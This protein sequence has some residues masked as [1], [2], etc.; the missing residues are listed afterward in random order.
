VRTAAQAKD[1]EPFLTDISKAGFEIKYF[2]GFNEPE[3][4]DQA[5][6]SVDEAVRLWRETVLPT[7]AK[8]GFRVGSPG[9][10]SDVSRSKPW[11]NSFFS[12]LGQD[13]GVDFLVVHWYGLRFEEM[14]R[15]LED[16]H[17][18]YG[19]PV[20]VNEFACSTMGNPGGQ[21]SITDVEKFIS[22]AVPWLDSCPWIERYAYYGHGQGKNVGDW[23][24]VANNLYETA[25]GC[26][27]TDGRQLSRVGRLYTEL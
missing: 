6:M 25:Q 22:E 8:L 15:F 2:L 9:M 18:T 21:S 27:Q 26:D 12:R 16:M 20:W 14:R 4:P 5:N 3:I 7:K 24:G 13:H 1:I 11:L 10:S 17:A 23:V 19:M